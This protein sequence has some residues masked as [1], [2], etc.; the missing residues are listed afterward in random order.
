M[1]LEL[2]CFFFTLLLVHSFA[3]YTSPYDFVSSSGQ[4]GV[5]FNGTYP[6]AEFFI[7]NPNSDGAVAYYSNGT[8]SSED[9]YLNDERANP[10]YRLNQTFQIQLLRIYEI[11]GTVEQGANNS[12]L[13][14]ARPFP[15][16]VETTSATND[17]GTGNRARN[18]SFVYNFFLKGSIYISYLISEDG[19]VDQYLE[20]GN[21]YNF[22]IGNTD[23]TIRMYI[24]VLNW[25]FASP[26]SRLGFEMLYL[27]NGTNG[28]IAADPLVPYNYTSSSPTPR[29]SNTALPISQ[30]SRPSLLGSNSV[31]ASF[32]PASLSQTPAVSPT[33]TRAQ[34]KRQATTPSFTPN[35]TSAS[36][37]A[38]TAAASST[39]SITSTTPSAV[40]TNNSGLTSTPSFA[41]SYY[42]PYGYSNAYDLNETDSTAFVNLPANA[43]IVD[44]TNYNYYRYGFS[45]INSA[46]QLNYYPNIS[47]NGS[48]SYSYVNLIFPRFQR[49]ATYG[50]SI[51]NLGISNQFLYGTP[52]YSNL[53]DGGKVAIAVTLG[54][55]AILACCAIIFCVLLILVGSKVAELLRRKQ[56]G[57]E[58]A[59][60][61]RSKDD[62]AEENTFSTT[63]KV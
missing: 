43:G 56:V 34:L 16:S 52:H 39:P 29:A 13:W 2:V 62:F 31:L 50:P 59:N 46:V 60:A 18:V 38:T 57:D 14:N 19:V 36:Q 54:V 10:A 44:G 5:A 20:Q 24:Q 8:D 12:V 63:G 61:Y 3:F 47:G 32:S 48:D 42:Y 22:G 17:A 49:S 27:V 58:K 53:D 25:I 6:S 7:V 33:I 45:N 23:R 51:H 26:D 35:P 11:N 37:T 1:K 55:A 15:A 21:Y 28:T 30:T 40:A 9:Y 41:S 4:W